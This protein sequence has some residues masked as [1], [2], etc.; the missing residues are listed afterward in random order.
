MRL[1]KTLVTT[2]ISL[3]LLAF[4]NSE[5]ALGAFLSS[6]TKNSNTSSG[7]W[8]TEI[9][10][11]TGAGTSSPYLLTWTGNS[12][13]QYELL[14]LINIGNFD[15]TAQHLTFS[16]AKA[17]GDTTNPPLLK[18]ETCSGVWDATTFLCSG[19][20]VL[21]GS[22]T[23]GQVNVIRYLVP[24]SRTILRVTNPRNNPGNYISTFNAHTF[25]NDIR[26]GNTLNT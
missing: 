19:S 23:G 16:T 12:N 20:I 6:H 5:S 4:P 22:A 9:A 1:A 18:F 26:S 11:A 3:S 14:S 13:K 8:K 7:S 2:A 25:R 10:S 24:G 21:I 17:N 15:L